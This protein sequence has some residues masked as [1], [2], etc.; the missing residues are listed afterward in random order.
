MRCRGASC[1]RVGEGVGMNTKDFGRNNVIWTCFIR[2]FFIVLVASVLLLFSISHV[3]DAATTYTVSD[4]ATGGDCA[5][6]GNWDAATKTC[7]LNR[8]IAIP[9]GKNGIGIY[10]V[11]ITLDGNGYTIT[12]ANQ[13][14]GVEVM[15]MDGGATIRNLN[16]QHFANGIMLIN[17][18]TSPLP[19]STVESCNITNSGNGILLADMS[20][21]H[22]VR[23]NTL[24]GNGVGVMFQTSGNNS[25]TENT[26]TGNSV[27]MDLFYY[28]NSNV[29][30]GNTIINNSQYGL[31]M[32]QSYGNKVYRNN[33]IDNAVQAY[34]IADASDYYGGGNL[35]DLAAPDG[36]NYWS[37][38]T[39]PD[40]NNDGFVDVRYAFT[41]KYD[42]HPWTT[43]NGWCD[44]TQLSISGPSPYW[45]NLSDYLGRRLSVDYSISNNSTAAA[46]DV[47]I[48]GT[49]NT[50]G[51]T[52]LSPLPALSLIDPGAS[53]SITIQYNVPVGVSAYRTTVYATASNSCG[54]VSS[55]PGP[56]QGP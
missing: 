42:N 8:D 9:G 14:S 12:G 19:G 21:R 33:F 48:I 22:T 45:A 39:S 43:M 55:Y 20:G 7:S 2:V 3:A 50:D 26:F 34:H 41:Y 10:S 16:V 56:W 44:D 28:A 52:S 38:W 4:N 32:V 17:D 31:R 24:N 1:R 30:R 53:A 18:G 15:T 13:Y 49:V 37:D 29:I 36:G 6:F 51:A 35:F 47:S 46:Y 5:A 25:V 11:G 23:N 40:A 27:G 54:T